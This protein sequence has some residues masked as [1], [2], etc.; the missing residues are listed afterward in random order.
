MMKR[1]GLLRFGKLA[2]YKKLGRLWPY[3]RPNRALFWLSCGL[4]PVISLVHLVQPMLLQRAIDEGILKQNEDYLLQTALFYIVLVT[5]EYLVRTLQAVST[6]VVVQKMIRLIRKRIVNHVFQLSPS[7]HDQA[8]SGSL[9]T[10][11][12]GDCDNLSES[13]SQGLLQVLVDSV[14]LVGA[15]VGMFILDPFL[16]A[17]TLVILP[18]SWLVI[19]G[20]ARSMKGALLR[21]RG[22]LAALNAFTQECLY[23]IRTVKVLTA[24]QE[25]SD[26]YHKVSRQYRRAQMRVVTLDAFLFSILDGLSAVTIGFVLWLILTRMGSGASL[27]AGVTIAFV[28]YIQQVFDPLKQLAGAIASLQGVL[29]SIDRIFDLLQVRN[30]IAGFKK[31]SS[32][33]GRVEFRDVSFSYQRDRSK[34][35][36]GEARVLK[37]VSL[38]I[39]AGTSMAL[40]G[41]TGSGKSTL[42]RLLSKLYDGYTG[43]IFLDGEDLSN[44]EPFDLRRQMSIVPQE[45]VLFDG[46]LAFNIALESNPDMEAVERVAHL[47]GL[48]RFVDSLPGGYSFEVVEGG[49][50]LSEGQKQL[51]VFARALYGDPGLIILDE[52]TASIDSESERMVQSA[53]QKVLSERTVLVIAHRL[54]TIVQCDQIAVLNQ[55]MISEV[56]THQELLQR[57][58]EYYRFFTA[59][60]HS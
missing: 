16:A 14:V 5:A 25:A 32:I 17:L 3:I 59:A 33:D 8:L 22:H 18:I 29:T 36:K 38:S 15:V 45:L 19:F 30:S 56:G 44:L 27:S 54:S 50:N 10:R 23:G 53:I 13:L 1:N 12:T 31:L 49:A 55:G 42:I 6:S 52:A 60:S 34:T 9:V 28:R 47:V 48:N 41:A 21:S 4:I 37:N 7:F 40:V 39:P 11:A 51:T 35:Q 26:R 2:E 57:R 58:G 20:F 24:E 46:S 43:K